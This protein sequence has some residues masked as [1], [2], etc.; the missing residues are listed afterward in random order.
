[1][2]YMKRLSNNKKALVA[3]APLTEQPKKTVSAKIAKPVRGKT[4]VS[5]P[6]SR[7]TTEKTKSVNSVEKRRLK[8][9]AIKPPVSAQKTKS[10][11]NKKSQATSINSVKSRVKKVKPIVSAE[12]KIK[13]AKLQSTASVKKIKVEGTKLKAVN[14]KFQKPKLSETKGT[15]LQETKS[16]SSK[17]KAAVKNKL[18]P[19]NIKL[20]GKNQITP[21]VKAIKNKI[22]SKK[23]QLSLKPKK[24]KTKPISSVVFRGKKD[25]YGF[26]VFPLDAEFEDVSAIYVISKRK[27]DKRKKGHHALVCIGQTE[28]LSGE[29]KR[30]KKGKCVKKYQANVISI[31]PEENE[32]KRLLIETDLK[33][34]HAVVCNLE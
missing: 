32:K 10:T 3:T 14:N 34:A 20:T 4:I 16:T 23:L 29:I 25:R 31:L 22:E 5:P 19:K 18:K 27:I 33:A 2:F 13:S 15:K 17:V 8:N 30:H 11:K 12:A 26:E 28:S 1:M 7:P 21:A 6:K 9:Q 24:K